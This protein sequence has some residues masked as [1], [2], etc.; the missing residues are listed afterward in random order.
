MS[1]CP[2]KEEELWPGWAQE[3]AGEAGCSTVSQEWPALVPTYSAGGLLLEGGRGQLK[4]MDGR[5][6]GRGRETPWDGEWSPYDPRHLQ[7]GDGRKKMLRGH[8]TS[9]KEG[10][11]TLSCCLALETTRSK[12]HKGVTSGQGGPET[13][14]F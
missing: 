9:G 7:E 11:V 14:L 6:C 12:V 10:P 3:G 13:C 5:G 8:G 4:G 1:R 2:Q